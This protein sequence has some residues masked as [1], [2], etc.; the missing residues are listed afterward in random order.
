MLVEQIQNDLREAI[1][2]RE[3]QR[4]S[5]LR[6]LTAELRN[7]EIAQKEPLTED[8]VLQVIQKQVDKHQDS[9]NQFSRAGRTDLA[10]KERTQMNFLQEY[11]PEPLSKEEV[12]RIVVDT[13]EE[14][15]A[16]GLKDLGRVM[17]KV[18]PEIRG[19]YD[20]SEVNKIAREKLG[21]QD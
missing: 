11:L 15:G 3:K 20:G 8:T 9:I 1:K 4:L 13:V 12:S 5:A 10:D 2:S 14:L 18:M 7:K 19:R 17:G 16:T 6:M 21:W